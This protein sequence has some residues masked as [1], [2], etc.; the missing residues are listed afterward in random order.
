MENAKSVMWH[1]QFKFKYTIL[2]NINKSVRGVK[3][4]EDEEQEQGQ[5]EEQNKEDGEELTSA[6]SLHWQVRFLINLRRQCRNFI[7]ELTDKILLRDISHQHFI[8][9]YVQSTSLDFQILDSVIR[10]I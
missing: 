10:E 7:K 6:N 4:K 3:E 2:I 5:D 8:Q 1:C 9:M